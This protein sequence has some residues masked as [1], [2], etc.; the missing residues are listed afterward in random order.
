V[1]D[2]KYLRAPYITTDNFKK[3]PAGE[4]WHP[5]PCSAN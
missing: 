1:K 2:P 5:T 4:G 3:I